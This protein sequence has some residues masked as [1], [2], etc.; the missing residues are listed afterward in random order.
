MLSS[1]DNEYQEVYFHVYCEKCKH[2]VKDRLMEPCHYCLENPVNL[3]S[4]KPVNFV[5][6]ADT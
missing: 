1:S 2:W 6:K 3:Q 5:E 4:H